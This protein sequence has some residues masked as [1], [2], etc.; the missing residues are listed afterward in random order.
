LNIKLIAT[1]LDGTLLNKS[2][3]ITQRNIDALKAA[4]DKGILI[5]PA[6]G[7]LFEGIPECVRTLPFLSYS[8]NVNG[9]TIYD[10]KKKDY[11]YSIGMKPETAVK[12]LD[13]IDDYDILYDAYIN[14]WGYMGKEHLAL[15]HTCIPEPFLT[16]VRTYRKPVDNLKEHILEMNMPV[17]K[18]QLFNSNK[19]VIGDIFDDIK[20]KFKDEVDVTSSLENNI[21]ICDINANKGKTLLKLAEM[22]G[23]K[24]EEI[25]AFGD[26]GNDI[27]ML[28]SVGFGVAMGNARD[29]VKAAAKYVTDDSLNDGVAAA[30]EKFIL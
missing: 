14:E 11:V 20:E 17:E 24:P 1:D 18:V 13:Y 4:S 25:M 5:V 23:I 30:I 3:T 15:A 10:Y 8:I 2:T 16:L 12:I 19:G 21:E 22:I 7:R 26:G 27:S 28:E 9:S 6:T 29:K